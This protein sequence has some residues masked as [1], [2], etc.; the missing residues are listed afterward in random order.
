MNIGDLAEL[1]GFI[2]ALTHKLMII[3]VGDLKYDKRVPIL[4]KNYKL[5]RALIEKHPDYIPKYVDFDS[6]EGILKDAGCL[7]KVNKS[8]SH[9][10]H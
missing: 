3:P 8:A 4:S 6:V 7:D 10:K 1:D 5:F 2:G 9:R